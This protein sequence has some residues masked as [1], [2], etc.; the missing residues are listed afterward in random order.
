MSD[1]SRE[2]RALEIIRGIQPL[3]REGEYC[4]VLTEDL[5]SFILVPNEARRNAEEGKS[6]KEETLAGIILA[7]NLS[8]IVLKQHAEAIRR[9]ESNVL[10]MPRTRLVGPDGSPVDMDS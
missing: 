9:E 4:A 8:S 2:N 6:T 1:S 7:H 3:L 5:Q 10:Q